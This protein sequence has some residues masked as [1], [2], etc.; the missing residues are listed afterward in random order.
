LAFEAIPKDI[1]KMM[2]RM[3]D[4]ATILLE[5]I[6]KENEKNALF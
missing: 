1:H 2:D 6:I 4:V 3:A 5:I